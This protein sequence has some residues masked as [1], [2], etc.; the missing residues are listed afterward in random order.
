MAA[1]RACLFV[2]ALT[3]G[4]GMTLIVLLLP[5]GRAWAGDSTPPAVPDRSVLSS[6]PAPSKGRSASP[7]DMAPVA[8][9]DVI[10]VFT[11]TWSYSTIGLVYDTSRGQVRYAH[12]SQSSTHNPTIYDV[13]YPVPHTL[14]YSTGLSTRNSGWPWQIDN[15]DGAGYDF[16]EDTYF[17]PDYNG[18]LSYA[19]DNIVEIDADGTILNAWEMDDEVGSNDSSDGSEI[20]S[21]IDIAV[22]PGSPARYFVAAAYDGNTVYAISLTKTGTW[23]TPNSWST[24]MTYTV[25][26][27]SDNLGIDYDAENGYL[28]HSGW[29][30]TTIVVTD[31]SLD[32]ITSFDCPGAGGYNSGVTVIEGAD[33]VWVTDFSSDKTTRCESPFA[34]VPL[35]P[36]WDKTVAG[37]PWEPGMTVVTQTGQIIV[38][39]DII[40][41]DQ[42]FTLTESGNPDRL[43]LVDQNVYPPLGDVIISPG[44]M[45]VIGPPGPPEVVAITKW[46]RVEPCDWISTTLEEALVIEGEPPFEA[47][48]VI[49]TK[50][51]PEL[52]IDSAYDTEVYAGGIT[53][54][55]L[56][57][58][59]TGGFENDVWISNTF[60]ITAPFV[61]AEPFPS[62]VAPG[63]LS[64]R[65]DVG[66][67]AQD[68]AG[69]I[70]VY[71]FI[72]ETV[73]A[74]STITIWDGIFNHVDVLQ[75]ETW[76]TFHVNDIAF[77]ITWEKYVN[78]IPWQPGIS[79]T[80]ETS[81]TLVI[82]E[83]IDPLVNPTGFSLIEEWN[84]EEL[85]LSFV[86][87][88]PPEYAAY[89]TSPAP[90]VWM[91]AVPPG[92]TYGPLTI[93]KEFH[94]E[95]CTWPETIL[96]ESLEVW[97]E[98]VR[99]RPVLVS[100][101]QPDLWIDSFFDVSVYSGD[102]AQFVL[103]YGNEGG[104]ENQAGIT[105]TFP[106]EA[107]FAWSDPAP[108]RFD[109]EN[110]RW[111]YW[112]V[113]SL[114]DGDGGSITVAVQIAPGLPPSTTIE[115][116]DGVF[117]HAGEL[118][119]ETLIIYHVPPPTWD[120]WVNGEEWT[121]GLGVTVETSDTITVVDVIST[122]SGVAIVEHWNPEH[123]ALVDYT[124][125]A[126]LPGIILSDTGF[127]AWEFPGGAPGQITITKI[128][129]VEP[130]TWTYTVLWEELWVEGIEWERRPVHIDR[131]PSDLWIDSNYDP[132][133]FAGQL[134]T[135]TLI[136]GNN[137]GFENQVGITN[138]FPAEATFVWSDPAPTAVDPGGRWA[139]WDVGSLA[140]GDG[141]SIT[142]TVAVAETLPPD[143]MLYIYDY[144]YDHAG[145]EQDWTV[146][147]LERGPSVYLPLVLRD[148]P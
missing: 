67:L 56:S 10:E 39:T 77:P 71:V 114:G 104:F 9:G 18:D 20:D 109:E 82:E 96:W 102:E 29:H 101:R 108:A 58:S 148:F 48:P 111:A 93:V 28:Y 47:R 37:R 62:Y 78:G 13:D 3:L 123:L 53:S 124:T 35:V 130:C 138:T 38:V 50:V 68:D 140:Q 145:V 60:P 88:L 7:P 51:P 119:D 19:D 103:T 112:D 55:T 143:T 69:S 87:I 107:P 137:G 85:A 15:R 142:V 64:V 5:D 21:I 144:I 24:V 59:N 80:L 131:T 84:P 139:Y 6:Q 133:V 81:Q 12:E 63:G 98:G 86:S 72:S 73:P 31:L 34:P 46:F 134:V 97:G 95:P 141:G 129:H 116:W 54:F 4:L 30:T 83:F 36:G 44:S 33:E 91:L 22:V 100:K 25:P 8:A 11:N 61:Y 147:V 49:I 52:Y 106:A 17:L 118:E 65:W 90:G 76:I 127:L 23:W 45:T 2:L 79:V 40:T 146:I 75:D 27:L 74:S 70:D 126:P 26:G 128:F 105:N 92:I 1:K 120:K 122:R 136:Y 117:N 125:E 57:Y 121:P 42:A 16:V 110:R 14:V 89:A 132:D 43:A 32:V 115:I 135:F 94:V 99:V 113:G 41:A 66:D